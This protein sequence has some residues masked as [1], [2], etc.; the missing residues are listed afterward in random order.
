[1]IFSYLLC[2]H[3]KIPECRFFNKDISFSPE[4]LPVQ[5]R[6]TRR[7]LSSLGSVFPTSQRDI[8]LLEPETQ[9]LKILQLKFLEKHCML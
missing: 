9:K 3:L 4:Q 8:L 5:G 1:M 2:P 7:H 6:G